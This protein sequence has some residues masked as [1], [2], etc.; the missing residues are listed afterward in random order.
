MVWILLAALGV[1][2]WLVVGALAGGL[3]SRRAFKRAPGVFRARLRLSNDG[4]SDAD[5]SWSRTPV[6]AR[7]A[8]DVLLVH[9]GFA[10]V[11]YSALPV[12]EVSGQLVPAASEDIKGLGAAPVVLTLALDDGRTAEVAARAEDRD[13]VVGPYALA[14][15]T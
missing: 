5:A 8:H 14:L 13:D 2:V 3:L 12:A 9:K 7:W 11:R 6:Y 4:A 1:P 15:A 10:L